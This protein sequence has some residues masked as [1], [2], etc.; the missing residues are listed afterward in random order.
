[1]ARQDNANRGKRAQLLLV[2]KIPGMTDWRR[3]SRQDVVS[4][5]QA[6]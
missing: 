5:N 1:M 6:R 3:R 2:G 4:V